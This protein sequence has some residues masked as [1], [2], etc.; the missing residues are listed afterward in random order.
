[1]QK[2]IGSLCLVL[3]CGLLSVQAA[4]PLVHIGQSPHPVIDGRLDDAGWRDCARVFPFVENMGKGLAQSQT[5]VRLYYDAEAFYLAFKCDEPMMD[6]IVATHTVRDRDVWRD[7]CVEIFIQIPDDITV[8]HILVNSEGLTSDSK[9]GNYGW[10]P[11]LD[12]APLTDLGRS[13][14][15]IEM[16][17]P[18]SEL[19]VVPKPG[20]A[21]HVN[22]TRQRKVEFERSAWSA[23][24]GT[25]NNATRF[26]TVTFGKA[27]VVQRVLEVAPPV[28][29]ANHARVQLG[30]R[31][32]MNAH[33]SGAGGPSIEIAHMTEPVDLMYPVG[34]CGDEVVLTAQVDQEPI[35]RAVFPCGVGDARALEEIGRALDAMKG[36]PAR[37]GA[38]HPLHA[39]LSMAVA[40]ALEAEGNLRRALEQSVAQD[41]SLDVKTFRA[42]NE[43]VKTAAEKLNH[44]RWVLWTKNNWANVERTEF[45]DHLGGVGEIKITSLVNEYEHANIVISNL[46]NTPLRLRADLTDLEWRGAGETIRFAGIR[47]EL[48]VADWQ[49]VVKGPTVADPLLPLG[50]AGRLDI[51]AGESRQL[52]LTLPAADLPPGQYECTLSLDPIGQRAIRG[53]LPGKTVKIALDIQPLRIAT[54]PDFAVYNWDYAGDE[55]YARDLYEHK[56]TFFLAPTAIPTP[57]F[58]AQGNAL[59]EIDYAD[60]DHLLRIKRKYA[61][62]AGGQIL[63]AYGILESFH[64]SIG[65]KYGFEYHSDAWDRAF[66]SAY[67]SWLAHLK[68]FGMG[69]DDFCVQVWDEALLEE[70]DHTVEGCKLLREIDPRV[71]LVMD[72]CQTVADVKRLDPYIDVWIPSLDFLIKSKDREALL[73][74]YHGLG[75]PVYCYTCSIN[76]KSQSPYDYHRLKPWKAASLGMDGVFFWA[77]NSWRGDP[78]DDYDGAPSNGTFYADCGVVYAGLTGPVTSRRWE[79]SRQGIEDWQ[80][81]RMTQRLADGAPD[82]EDI[83]EQIDRAIRE[84]VENPENLELAQQYRLDLIGTATLLAAR[85][86]LQITDCQSKATRRSLRV[87]FKTNRLAEGRLFYRLV[88]TDDWETRN[89]A[90]ARKH[91]AQLV[92]PPEARA[93]W[94]IL[95]WDEDGRVV[96]QKN[97]GE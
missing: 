56:V 26:G 2:A 31:P 97:K 13:G 85:D 1:M 19:G 32:Q 7:D 38:A 30:L 33:L 21:W 74:T 49:D 84:V 51:P 8:Y 81:I 82:E 60:Y 37:L 10:D 52:W 40:Q 95:A 4:V 87:A 6:E 78:W 61:E 94:L 12:I 39:P 80:I 63:F 20:D 25:F 53:S 83:H 55:A 69:Y 71:R 66:R 46:A 34:L 23:T 3:T 42:L 47:P 15:G 43:A 77:Y 67:T 89:L 28:L 36:A 90:M 24:Y 91:K 44:M 64:A 27:P 62:K 73:E 59:G 76:M 92:L 58:D 65:K 50:I 41:R 18:W 29:G 79:A 22:F 45:P 93:D 68:A 14:W 48:S 88:G 75:E 72:G 35:W 11:Q 70:I 54:S 96:C 17:I 86:P 16:A 9:F 57:E 5:E